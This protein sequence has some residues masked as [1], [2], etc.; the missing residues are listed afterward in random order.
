MPYTLN[1]KGVTPAGGV[2]FRRLPLHSYAKK[3]EIPTNISVLTN[4]SNFITNAVESLIYYYKK[5]EVYT[6]AEINALLS[7]LT[8]KLSAEIVAALPTENISTSTMYLIAVDGQEGVYTQYMYIKGEWAVLGKT[9][10]DLS[11]YYD[12]SAVDTK[13]DGKAD[14][15]SIPTV[16][17]N[18]SAFTNDA[19][20]I[21]EHQPLTEYAKKVDIPVVHNDLTDA[22]KESYDNAAAKS[23]EHLNKS[24]LDNVTAD[25]VAEYAAA[26]AVKHS[27]ANKD[28]IDVISADKITAWD[29]SVSKE[30]EHENKDA[31]DAI[32]SDKLAG[33]D[34][35]V[36]SS[37]SHSNK[38]AINKFT[39]AEDGTLLYDGKSF[40][41]ARIN[42]DAVS[43]VSTWSSKKINDE[44][45]AVYTSVEDLN[46]RKGLTINLVN[47]ED[48]TQTLIDALVSKECFVDWFSNSV[49]TNRF[50]IIT[51]TYG[52]KINKLT[53][54]KLSS[55]A[56]VEAYMNSGAI[57]NRTYVN[58]TLSDW[59]SVGHRL[60]DGYTDDG[61]ISVIGEKEDSSGIYQN[62][63]LPETIGLT[64]DIMTWGNGYYR[65][66]H[67]VNLTNTPAGL[68]A[69]RLEHF[70]IKRWGNDHNPNTQTYGERF[71]V[72]YSVDGNIYTRVTASGATAGTYVKDTGWRTITQDKKTLVTN[73]QNFK[74]SITKNNAAW[75]GFLKFEYM[76][77]SRLSEIVIGI[78]TSGISYGFV[79][80]GD[81]IDSITYTMDGANIN[82]G[83][84]FK[85]KVYGTQ[86]VEMPSE[87]GVIN[88]FTKDEFTGDATATRVQDQRMPILSLSQ[89]GLDSSS[90]VIATINAMVGGQVAIIDVTEYSN[91]KTYFPIETSE[92]EFSAI[93]IIKSGDSPRHYVKWFT[94]DGT[95]E[96]IAQFDS[97]N[98]ISGWWAIGANTYYSIEHA[99]GKW[100]DG[101][102]VY[103]KCYSASGISNTSGTI[104][105]DTLSLHSIISIKGTFKYSGNTLPLPYGLLTGGDYCVVRHQAA[106][107]ALTLVWTPGSINLSGYNIIV[108][109]TKV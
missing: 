13:L 17:N 43:Q 15:A 86:S 37:H 77:G 80:G 34:E 63:V 71:S 29:N 69:G 47:G 40:E 100:I 67:G 51:N 76:H 56:T 46:T 42:D 75:Y 91:Y 52:D 109:Y 49:S 105:L 53:I 7:N 19:G 65:I 50:G 26:V 64:R 81:I 23:H 58:G 83:V 9:S 101:K 60:T 90:T 74:I 104:T 78:L 11:S 97:T 103:R 22:L 5:S 44:T 99:V 66:S 1:R 31:L 106:N 28:A 24:V 8:G 32:T 98:S 12:K 94:K 18:V 108:E 33:Y 57:L 10:V 54:T 92:D 45:L 36:D 4:D 70:N 30:H 88:S 84:N 48:N 68:Q 72:W 107:N 27:H 16:P 25:A 93:L 102:R 79:Q 62:G 41:G 95:K 2:V 73:S 59:Y 55:D 39:E 35:A 3:N 14:K 85:T 61:T 89:L 6:Q 87:F 96:F 38:S 82:L 21:T 20:Y